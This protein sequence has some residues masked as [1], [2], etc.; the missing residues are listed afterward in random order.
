M[1]VSAD[2]V[3]SAARRTKNR[4]IGKA[5][6]HKRVRA[7]PIIAG[8]RCMITHR[9]SERR[10]F[11]TP[12][13]K[14]VKEH[15]GFCLAV[16]SM[17]YGTELHASCWMG[18][19]H[20]T[21]QTDPDAH[22]PLYKDFLHSQVARGINARRGR[23][24]A[25]WHAGG[26]CDTRRLS[27]DE[28][29]DDLV[30]ILTNPVKDGLVKTGARWPGFTT[31]GWRF[32]ETRRFRRSAWYFDPDNPDI[33]EYADLTL[34]RPKIMEHLSDDEL[35]ELLMQRVKAKE[36]VIQQKM[37]KEGKRFRGESKV[38]KQR[39]HRAPATLGTMFTIAPRV[40]GWGWARLAQLQRDR[41]WEQKY[42]DAR[43]ARK[44]D[45]DAV[46]PY[47]TYWMRVH[48]GVKVAAAEL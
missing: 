5:L 48:I 15:I 1:P 16:A 45:N 6:G 46:F 8:R 33:P 19:H 43:E 13:D 25:F 29:L 3:A 32:G 2:K 27:E 28:S 42:A 35:Y 38:A 47:G 20:H 22:L 4:S 34:H 12:N 7:K 41:D 17:R 21:T 36:R 9:S 31:Y 24:G 26:S 23:S 11:L 14:Q 44:S 10:L 18:N 40:A 30:Y 39:W 37:A